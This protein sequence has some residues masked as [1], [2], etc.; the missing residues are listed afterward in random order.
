MS[1]D[2]ESDDGSGND[3]DSGDGS[4]H[5]GGVEDGA[6]CAEIWERLSERREE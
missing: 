2:G 4:D 6:G 1:D 3:G 5:L